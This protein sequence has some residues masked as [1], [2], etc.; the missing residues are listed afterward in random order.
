MAKRQRLNERRERT[1]REGKC[2]M[3]EESVPLEKQYTVTNDL[4]SGK[5]GKR[6]NASRKGAETQSHYCDT[7]AEK[8]VRQKQAWLNARA[9]QQAKGS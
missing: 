8:R 5:A 9:K 3:C 7:C 1:R 2:Q 4:K 6:K